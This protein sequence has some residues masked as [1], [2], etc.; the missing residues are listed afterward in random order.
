[1]FLSQKSIGDS[2]R[3]EN[4]AVDGEEKTVVPLQICQ[5]AWYKKADVS[6]HLDLVDQSTDIA[7]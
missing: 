4:V 6:A 2:I 3:W 7:P 1:M 5:W